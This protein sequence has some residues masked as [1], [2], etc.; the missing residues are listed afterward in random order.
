VII[1]HDCR[2]GRSWL[3]IAVWLTS[4][5]PCENFQGGTKVGNFCPSREQVISGI[6]DRTTKQA[7]I[8]NIE[9]I[10]AILPKLADSVS[11]NSLEIALAVSV[12]MGCVALYMSRKQLFTATK[13]SIKQIR[14]VLGRTRPQL[15]YGHEKNHCEH[16]L[17]GFVLC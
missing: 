13:E 17:G 14:Q 6:D 10:M 5:V 9:A 7:A 2:S 15:D 1:N 16:W 4:N 8:S 11:W 12:L 3:R